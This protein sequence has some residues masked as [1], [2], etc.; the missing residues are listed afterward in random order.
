MLHVGLRGCLKFVKEP[1]QFGP[2]VDAGEEWTFAHGFGSNSPRTVT[3][4]TS[5]IGPMAL[6]VARLSSN[7]AVD[8]HAEGVL[9]FA[10]PTYF[11][12]NA[13]TVFRPPAATFR[14]AAGARFV[15]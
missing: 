12:D 14:V 3:G 5:I 10:R 8:L 1:F 6:V 9:P 11:I 7:V 15:F 2:C 4:E 13:G